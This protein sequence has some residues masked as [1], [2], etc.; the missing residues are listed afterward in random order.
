MF[1]N[2]VTTKI[3][4]IHCKL[5]AKIMGGVHSSIYMQ[6]EYCMLDITNKSGWGKTY[7]KSTKKT[8]VFFESV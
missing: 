8:E 6:L 7:T 4:P 5:A 1:P 3:N 2:F